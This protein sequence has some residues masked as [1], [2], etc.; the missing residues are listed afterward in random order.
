M[1]ALGASSC[2]LN[3]FGLFQSEKCS[4]HVFVGLCHDF[5]ELWVVRGSLADVGVKIAGNNPHLVLH[6]LRRTIQ[7]NTRIVRKYTQT[8]RA[9][10]RMV[11]AYLLALA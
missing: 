2:M 7:R 11:R 6:A 5:E 4:P 9:Y 8:I 10:S 1:L 3:V